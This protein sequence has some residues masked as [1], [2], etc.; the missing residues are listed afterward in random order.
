VPG[1]VRDLDQVRAALH[2]TRHE[3][4]AEGMAAKGRG[5]EAETDS[6]LFHDGGDVVTDAEAP[7]LPPG[8]A[9]LPQL[10]I[11]SYS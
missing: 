11:G 4:G 9:L 8:M 1:H 7:N 2:G 3:A 5:I 10:P 6:A